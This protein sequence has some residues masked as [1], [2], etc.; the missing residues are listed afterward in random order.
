M[1]V[2]RRIRQ[3][4]TRGCQPP[5]GIWIFRRGLA[6]NSRS[7]ARVSFSEK[8]NGVE[9]S[10]IPGGFEL[11]IRL[12]DLALERR[13]VSRIII[14]ITA[15][16]RGCRDIGKPAE[17]RYSGPRCLDCFLAPGLVSLPSC[18]LATHK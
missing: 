6:I 9:I 13:F 7:F 12:L 11:P 8:R 15:G 3:I 18:S 16:I 5:V 2:P 10:P 17:G 14:E 4:E 1:R